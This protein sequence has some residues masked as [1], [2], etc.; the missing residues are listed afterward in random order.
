MGRDLLREA[1]VLSLSL[2]LYIF[3]IFPPKH[4][5]KYLDRT[6]QCKG[7]QKSDNLSVTVLTELLAYVSLIQR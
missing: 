1:S 3:V 5:A 7:L 6:K 4:I 2:S